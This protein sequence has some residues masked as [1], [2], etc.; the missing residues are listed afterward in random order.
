MVKS[1]NPKDKGG[2]SITSMKITNLIC[3]SLQMVM[4]ISNGTER[5]LEKSYSSK[6]S[7]QA[8][9]IYPPLKVNPAV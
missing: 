4:K 7:Q 6:V 1:Y 5:P 3:S 2:L 9:W 8:Y